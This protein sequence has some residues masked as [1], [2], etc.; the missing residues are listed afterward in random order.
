MLKLKFSESEPNKLIF[1]E[2]AWHSA[3]KNCKLPKFSK[4]VENDPNALKK[5]P[6]IIFDTFKYYFLSKNQN[7][8]KI[9]LIWG[10]HG[11][12]NFFFKTKKTV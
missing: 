9:S 11:N 10:F 5:S 12:G 8:L 6:D 3:K 2:I 4:I 7:Q 1:A